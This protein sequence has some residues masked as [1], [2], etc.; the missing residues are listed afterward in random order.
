MERGPFHGHVIH[1]LPMVINFS[2]YFSSF[3]P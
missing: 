1:Y 2:V 3:I